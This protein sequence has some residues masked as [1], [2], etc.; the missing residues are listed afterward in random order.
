MDKHHLL[1]NRA[2]L[3][4]PYV[5]AVPTLVRVPEDETGGNVEERV[6]A[7]TFNNVIQGHIMSPQEA[8]EYLQHR[9]ELS[10]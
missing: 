2:K 5:V 8:V 9:L 6:I 1:K 10:P 4:A 3:Q 7:V